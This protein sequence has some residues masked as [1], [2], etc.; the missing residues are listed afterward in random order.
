MSPIS[1]LTWEGLRA[2][3]FDFM[4]CP[5]GLPDLCYRGPVS[6]WPVPDIFVIVA[7]TW[8]EQLKW[9]KNL[10]WSIVLEIL[11]PFRPVP[12]SW[13]VMRQDIQVETEGVWQIKV[14]TSIVRKQR[15]WPRSTLPPPSPTWLTLHPRPLG[16][17]CPHLWWG[18]PLICCL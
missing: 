1:Y 17:S 2:I 15:G 5:Q 7:N 10:L 16:W 6:K 12:S 11:V 14:L 4:S 13:S 18:F 8:E 9:R 3:S